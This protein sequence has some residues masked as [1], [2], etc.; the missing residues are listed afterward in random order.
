MRTSLRMV[1][2]CSTRVA[3][4]AVTVALLGPCPA[5]FMTQALVMKRRSPRDETGHR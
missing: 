3:A 1:R 4:I 2:S 5:S